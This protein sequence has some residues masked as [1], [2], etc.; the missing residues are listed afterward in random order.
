VQLAF[1]RGNKAGIKEIIVHEGR[2]QFAYN[3]VRCDTTLISD[4]A[5]G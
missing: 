1:K 3:C 5:K 2:T 4:R